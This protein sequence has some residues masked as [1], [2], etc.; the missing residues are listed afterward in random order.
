MPTRS[1]PARAGVP[2]SRG[3]VA[4]A[5]GM[6]L[7]GMF[8][9][10]SAPPS[11]AQS[12]GGALVDVVEAEG[13]VDGQVADYLVGVLETA[14]ADG[15]EVVVL[16]L[17]VRG[18]IGGA[19][20]RVAE[21]IR[22]SEVPVVTWVGP[23]GARATGGGLLIAQAGHLRAAAPGTMLGP[24][25]PVD[26]AATE[27]AAETELYAR[28]A[29]AAGPALEPLLQGGA[30]AVAPASGDQT[31]PADVKLPPGLAF[32]DV[33]VAEETAAVSGGLLD[34]TA[35]TLPSLLPDLEGRQVAAAG[36]DITLDVDPATANPRFNNLGIVR[37]VLHAVATPTLAYVLLVGGLLALLFEVFQPGFGVAGVSG[38]GLAALGTYGFVILPTRWLA[39]AALVVG[40]LLLAA[41]LAIGRLGVLTGAGT[42]AV[43]AGSWWLLPGPAP[44]EIP[45]WVVAL[46][47]VTVVVYFVAVMTTVL[48]AQG[49]QAV[50][51]A[52]HVIG[53]AG[54]V[55]SM[56]NPEG[57]VFVGGALWRARAPDEAGR[58]KAGT[59][60][61]VLGLSDTLTLEVAPIT[62]DGSAAVDPPSSSTVS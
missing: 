33:T 21:A 62:E 34:L 38:L 41:D 17:D 16:Q 13:V 36:S 6:L 27:H 1:L 53:E 18:A 35:P 61:R 19:A 40:L 52:E 60:V 32:G 15:A 46:V 56:L 37:Q 57:H 42:V 28:L 47:T 51:G 31:L 54:V 4:L 55:R 50:A 9:L 5:V 24:A 45:L 22:A 58:V 59:P 7:A 23:A 48:R 29:P 12:R 49:N 14:A 20:E 3:V 30:V 2:L 43:A 26:L 25:G 44:L 11:A 39:F 10:A 8:L